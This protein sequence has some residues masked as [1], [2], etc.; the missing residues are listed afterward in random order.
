MIKRIIAA[1][2][3]A[4]VVSV[5]L[6][7]F[8]QYS[9]FSEQAAATNNNITENDAAEV[10]EFEG[11][12][13]YRA[14][15]QIAQYIGE[16]YVD[17]SVTPELAI[18]KG[19]SSYLDGNDKALWDLLKAMFKSLDPW[20]DF[21]TNSEYKEY[22]DNINRTFYGIGISIIENEGYVEIAGF[23]E[24]GGLAQQSGFK[25]GDK[26]A[27]VAG[28]DCAGKS[29][30]AVR[31]LIV[32]ELGT[33]VTVTV[34]RDGKLIDIIATRTEVKQA[35][36]T[37]GIFE[38]NI[39]YLRIAS[40]GSETAAEVAEGLDFFTEN[41]VNKFILDLRDNG[42]GMLDAAV[43][44]AQMLIPKGKII[45]VVYREE[46][47]NQ[48]YYAEGASTDFD[49]VVLVNE[50]TASASEVLA[51][52]IQDSGTGKLVGETTYGKAVVQQVFPLQNGM[53]FKLT[54]GEYITRNGKSINLVGLEPDEFV[55]NTT[56]M[57]DSTKYTTFDFKT[58]A[59]LG[60][61]TKNVLA[62]KE[63]LG[64][65][66]YYN[67][68]AGDMVFNAELKDAIK[69]FQGDNRLSASGVLDIATQVKIEDEFEKLKTVVDRQLYTAYE[70]LGGDPAVLM[71]TE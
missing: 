69:A 25:V 42:G 67:G 57:I 6:S 58:R 2:L 71:E 7:G 49:I 50:Y 27:K 9:S 61:Y 35:T 64:L 39:G 41:G 46:V 24:E 37:A 66:G 3:C 14:L 47:N 55:N 23:T 18:E 30:N 11:S 68:R 44:I 29:T 10:Q 38:G 43:E 34:L 51:S 31:N 4:A 12:G 65:L 19:L 8:A 16:L 5:P 40:F 48:S 32:G 56:Q 28:V 59:S 54:V 63:K 15:E 17:E 70:M 22:Q 62:A 36:A 52:A 33:K 26:I 20:C 21:Y 13:N 53:Y 45:D 1:M 60:D